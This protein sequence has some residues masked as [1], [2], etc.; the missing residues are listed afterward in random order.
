MKT[1]TA[2]NLLN[3]CAYTAP[4]VVRMDAIYIPAAKTDTS[5]AISGPV[6]SVV[7]IILPA[8]SVMQMV[9]EVVVWPVRICTTLPAGSGYI[10]NEGDSPDMLLLM[11][12]PT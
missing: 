9:P 3:L 11:F 7:S 10:V 12:T 4:S 8:I 1:Y 6:F 2:Y 5:T